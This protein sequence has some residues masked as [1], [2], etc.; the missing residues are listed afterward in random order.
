MMKAP[1]P[2]PPIKRAPSSE[3][4]TSP[5][6][7]ERDEPKPTPLPVLSSATETPSSPEH[8]AGITAPLPAMPRRAA[9]P[10]RK[11]QKSNS[12][13]SAPVVEEGG[14]GGHPIPPN[15]EE[16]PEEKTEQ[17]VEQEKKA[18]EV[19]K[20]EEGAKG[21]ENAGIAL[22]PVES[23]DDEQ[24][25]EGSEVPKDEEAQVEL[26]KVDPEVEHKEKTLAIPV[27]DPKKE[28]VASPAEEIS[29][30]LSIPDVAQAGHHIRRT[31]IPIP[32]RDASY[33]ET[34]LELREL[35]KKDIG[36][37]IHPVEHLED[38]P[39]SRQSSLDNEKVVEE[40]EEAPVAKERKRSL[41]SIPI[42]EENDA[43][44]GA[45]TDLL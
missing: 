10:R 8:P 13:S 42:V 29:E 35:T 34:D 45:N 36:P 27:V 2:P 38:E 1:P 41:P 12:T 23:N 32:P 44:K 37:P 30:P 9:P 19:G 17:E 31:S 43:V 33:H 26:I 25:K 4:P 18:E 3:Q 14:D 5:D 39:A 40:K 11:P 24:A 22:A 7:V 21:A 20:G 15:P 16:I 28:L 6:A